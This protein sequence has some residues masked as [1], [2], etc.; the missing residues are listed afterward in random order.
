MRGKVGK[1]LS[2]SGVVSQFFC[3]AEVARGTLESRS[4]TFIEKLCLKAYL[5]YS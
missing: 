2:L 5:G 1:I 3:R 4:H